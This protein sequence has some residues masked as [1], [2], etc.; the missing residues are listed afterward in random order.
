MFFYVLDASGEPLEI[1][2]EQEGGPGDVDETLVGDPGGYGVHGIFMADVV[3][4]AL[5][6]TCLTTILEQAERDAIMA[7]LEQDLPLRFGGDWIDAQGRD[8]DT[9]RADIGP[10]EQVPEWQ[11]DDQIMIRLRFTLEETW[12]TTYSLSS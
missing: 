7:A 9:F 2:L 12:T 10:V 8:S 3:A 5:T 1:P 11:I 4:R 6:L